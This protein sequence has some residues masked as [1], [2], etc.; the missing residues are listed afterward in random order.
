MTYLFLCN[1]HCLQ[2]CVCV[3]VC[4]CV[5]ACVCA[6]LCVCVH[7]CLCVRAYMCVCVCVFGGGV[8]FVWIIFK[9]L[10]EYLLVRRGPLHLRTQ[11]DD[12]VSYYGKPEERT[13][14]FKGYATSLVRS[15]G[16]P[17]QPSGSPD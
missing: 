15:T 10:I 11:S 9:P 8:C 5:C 4:V 1:G 6:C 17:L 16:F 13:N 3:C 14:E 2:Q 12:P 7:A